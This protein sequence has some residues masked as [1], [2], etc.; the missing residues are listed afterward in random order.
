[1][2]TDEGVSIVICCHNSSEF[3][4]ETLKHICKLSVPSSIKWEVIIID[5]ASSDNTS[6]TAISLMKEFNC[7]VKFRI[8]QEPKLGLSF[9][10]KTGLNNA[11]YRYILFCDD[12]NWLDESYI[13]TGYEILESNDRIGALGG[14]SEAVTEGK[15]PEWFGENIKNYSVGRQAERSGELKNSTDVLWGAGLFIRKSALQELYSKGFN[16]FLSDRKGKELTSGGDIEKCYALRLA[17]WKIW[18]DERL[19]IKHFIPEVRL[20]WEYLRKLNRGYG[21]QKV[22]FDPYLNLFIN[23]GSNDPDHNWHKEA[24][25]LLR[26]LRGYGFRKLFAMKDSFEGDKE[27]LRIEK[28]IGRLKELLKIRSKYN[29]R[30]REVKEARWRKVFS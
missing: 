26:K 18:Y 27:I 5:N 9:A 13:K 15:I 25:R 6:D 23:S 24:I 19:K 22:D 7:P 16:S 4:P 28:T 11:E 2:K 30:I 14:V 10:R 8:I 3:L 12:D 21:A 20:N 17:G 1:M 29:S